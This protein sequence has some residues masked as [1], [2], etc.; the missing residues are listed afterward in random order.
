MFVT[1]SR[2]IMV[3]LVRM[4]K[5]VVAVLMSVLLMWVLWSRAWGDQN[6]GG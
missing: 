5:L 2:V 4:C 1:V 3:V 6:I